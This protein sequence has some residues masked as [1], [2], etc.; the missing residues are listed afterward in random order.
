MT[1]SPAPMARPPSEQ[2][3]DL[4][5]Y[6]VPQEVWNEKYRS[7]Y[8]DVIH[9]TI[10]AGFLRVWP[11][12]S[13]YYL[14]NQIIEQLGYD[15]LPPEYVFLKS[16]GRCL[17]QVKSKQEFEL[18]V[19]NFIP[20]QVPLPEIFVLEAKRDPLNLAAFTN[21]ERMDLIGAFKQPV[22]PLHVGQR[23]A[24]VQH[25]SDTSQTV[26]SNHLPDISMDTPL[27]NQSP[28]SV[29][30]PH[31]QSSHAFH[32]H[33]TNTNNTHNTSDHVHNSFADHSPIYSTSPSRLPLLTHRGSQTNL[34]PDLV[35][36]NSRISPGSS[37]PSQDLTSPPRRKTQPTRSPLQNKHGSP[38]SSPK[39]SPSNH[40]LPH[41]TPLPPRLTQPSDA[42]S[43]P[44]SSNNSAGSSGRVSTIVLP[45]EPTKPSNPTLT[46]PLV[47][48]PQSNQNIASSSVHTNPN[49]T[50][51][52]PPPSASA[53]TNQH[54]ESPGSAHWAM[55]QTYRAFHNEHQPSTCGTTPT[56]SQTPNVTPGGVPPLHLQQLQ[57]VKGIDPSTP[58]KSGRLDTYT[59]DTNQDSGIAEFT[60][61]RNELDYG[62]QRSDSLERKQTA[63]KQQTPRTFRR[64]RPED[65]DNRLQSA[66]PAGLDRVHQQRDSPRQRLA[67]NAAVQEADRQREEEEKAR[68]RERQIQQ[69]AAREHAEKQRHL[70]SAQQR[71]TERWEREKKEEE[72]RQRL[73]KARQQELEMRR[74]EAAAAQEAEAKQQAATAAAEEAK[75]QRLQEE[76]EEQEQEEEIRKRQ[77]DELRQSRQMS[78]DQSRRRELEQFTPLSQRAGSSQQKDLYDPYARDSVRRERTGDLG[79]ET[80]TRQSERTRDGRLSLEDAESG[81]ASSRDMESV[82]EGRTSGKTRQMTQSARERLE[83]ERERLLAEL[84]ERQEMRLELERTREELMRQAKT[85]QARTVDRKNKARDLWKKKYFEEKKKTNPLEEQVNRLRSQLDQQHRKLLNQLEGRGPQRKGM[86]REPPSKKNDHK[87]LIFKMQ[88][89]MDDLRRRVENSKMKLTSEIKLRT[90]AETEL[91][92][93]RTDVL[94]R[95]INV[96]VSRS[97]QLNPLKETEEKQGVRTTPLRGTGATSFTPRGMVRTGMK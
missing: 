82:G 75:R 66:E 72:E 16:V 30:H 9:Q 28:R 31:S 3:V 97:Q 50:N 24:G 64:G 84:Q 85:L 40:S 39:S 87:I 59:N 10:S 77:A 26:H 91:R 14:R 56:P 23:D 48:N 73:L 89:Q 4:H 41:L 2:L 35:T 11:E 96:T 60:P 5:V 38:Q 90:Q 57:A 71:E 49:P 19:K 20:P 22:G 68:Q 79:S 54:P 69:A 15:V 78:W 70:E 37:K 80:R 17:T 42:D 63:E 53:S 8:N 36:I 76:A 6:L 92:N 25:A 83:L 65:L 32:Q 7:A 34:M 88:H 95:K 86:P 1:S 44:N 62:R 81:V 29:R 18:K 74:K 13:L 27:P 55:P 45:P 33:H 58:L 21:H 61:D 12:L 51:V 52:S 94:Q 47:F 46:N 67:S 43:S 93:L